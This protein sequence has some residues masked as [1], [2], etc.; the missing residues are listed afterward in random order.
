VQDGEE[1]GPFH[2]ELEVPLSQQGEQDFVDGT[3]LPE[4]LKNEG[5]ADLGGAS[6]NALAAGVGTEDGEFLREAAKRVEEGIDVATGEEFIEA[7]ESMQDA[8]LDL[9]VN[10]LVV[11]DEEISAG[12]VGLS[13]N[14]QG[15]APV[16]S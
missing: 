2:R 13:A 11:D 12:T 5:R 3:E 4:A 16:S 9:T 14:E 7:A 10:P 6:G 8:L 15:G 1:D